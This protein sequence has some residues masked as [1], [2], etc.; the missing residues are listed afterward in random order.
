L[1]TETLDRNPSVS[2]AQPALVP[3][4]VNT[5]QLSGRKYEATFTLK[6]GGPAGEVD[7]L[8]SGTDVDGQR[9][10]SALS[11]PLR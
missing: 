7:F 5:T 8:V 1:S 4:T 6:S 10:S 3:W 9:Q 2:V 11:L